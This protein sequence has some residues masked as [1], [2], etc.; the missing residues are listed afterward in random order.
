MSEI[1]SLKTAFSANT[2]WAEWSTLIVFIGLLGDILVILIFDLFDREKSR[3]EVLLAAAASLVI[4]VGVYGEYTFTRKATNA[5][6]QL[7]AKSEKE[8]AEL[9]KEAAD[10]RFA[11]A[12]LEKDSLVLRGRLQDVGKDATLANVRIKKA[13]ARIAELKVEAKT[14]GQKIAEANARANEAEAHIAAADEKA[15]AERLARVKL[16][17]SL[18]WRTLT[19]EQLHSI[20]VALSAFKGEKIDIFAYRD[21][22]DAM[23]LSMHLGLALGGSFISRTPGTLPPLTFRRNW[24]LGWELDPEANRGKFEFVPAA[25]WIV[26]H[27]TVLEFS[28]ID[29]TGI[30]VETTENADK[31]DVEAATTLV[32]ALKAANLEASGPTPILPCTFSRPTCDAR[33]RDVRGIDGK[34]GR[35]TSPIELTILFRPPPSE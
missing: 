26:H 22:P 13:D 5:S 2:Y 28:R 30:E 35:P 16:E 7:Q 33:D 18:S 3:W 25:G 23:V 9:N 4:T 17:K 8:I 15:E 29:G 14:S 12:Q 10:A 32:T 11:Q 6:L 24:L 1:E 21:E 20:S 34:I 31:G 19:E 27:F